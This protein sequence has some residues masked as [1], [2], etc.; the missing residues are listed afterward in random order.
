M[1]NLKSRLLQWPLCSIKDQMLSKLLQN[2]TSRDPKT[3]NTIPNAKSRS[4]LRTTIPMSN[5][6]PKAEAKSQIPMTLWRRS[7]HRKPRT[8][9]PIPN[10]RSCCGWLQSCRHRCQKQITEATS[11]HTLW[12]TEWQMYREEKS[13]TQKPTSPLQYQS[14]E[15]NPKNSANKSL[16]GFGDLQHS[17]VCYGG[18][19]NLLN[20]LNL[21]EERVRLLSS[22]GLFM[23]VGFPGFYDGKLYSL[24]PFGLFAKRRVSARGS[25]HT[26]LWASSLMRRRE[27]A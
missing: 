14:K 17:T 3:L 8:Q 11:Q 23:K 21:L 2:D 26:G 12:S 16:L 6:F 9:N 25:P 7:S 10:A 24:E 4:Q 13:D 15:S 18:A 19:Q 1:S 5:H 20:L 22:T 27:V